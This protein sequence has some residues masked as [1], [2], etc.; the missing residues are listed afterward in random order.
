M[1]SRQ[2]LA[3][4]TH[5]GGGVVGKEVAAVSSPLA[6]GNS[7]WLSDV[8]VQL[9]RGVKTQR[10]HQGAGKEFHIDSLDLRTNPPANLMMAKTAAG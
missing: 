3:E 6:R 9:V 5:R 7:W 2:A 1:A 10:K 4:R 8:L